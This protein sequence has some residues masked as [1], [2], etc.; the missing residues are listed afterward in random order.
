MKYLDISNLDVFVQAAS[1]SC[2]VRCGVVSRV[3]HRADRYR[4]QSI[5]LQGRSADIG[6]G[7]RGSGTTHCHSGPGAALGRDGGRLRAH[8]MVW[9]IGHRCYR[10][11]GSHCCCGPV[12]TVT[13]SW[14][15]VIKQYYTFKTPFMQQTNIHFPP[16]KCTCP[17]R[18]AS[19]IHSH[20][21]ADVQS[22]FWLL[23]CGCLSCCYHSCRLGVSRYS[24]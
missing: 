16:S 4:P 12:L 13:C 2:A 1:E 24:A 15:W 8:C 9:E 7:K 18:I 11:D 3:V 23:T 20:L 14:K 10:L 5:T 17:G 22:D 19:L 6:W 21:G